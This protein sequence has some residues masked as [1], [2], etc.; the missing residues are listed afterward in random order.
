[1]RAL[2]MAGGAGSRLNLGEKPLILLA[3]QPMIGYVLEAF[4]QA[5]VDPVLA[6]SPKTP[7]TLNWCKANGI[8]Y[9][10]AGGKGYVEDMVEAVR[11]M[12][13]TGPLF[14]SVSDIP[15]ITAD[16]V[17]R[18]AARYESSGKDALSVWVPASRVGT[19]RGGMPYR[20][21]IG[22]IVA[23][24][25]GLNI[26]RGDRIDEVQDELQ[27]RLDEP[28]LALNINTRADLARAE[29]FMRHNSS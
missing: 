24:P 6:V 25:A 16:I 27:I 23:C 12:E 5:G 29:A 22:G 21:S 17:R 9:C 11:L 7:M 26:L 15:C 13:E 3:G 2:I 20:E 28:C 10:K 8:E 19:C 14:I 18:I 1:M 4:R